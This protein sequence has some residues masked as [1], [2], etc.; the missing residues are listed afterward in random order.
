MTPLALRATQVAYDTVAADYSVLLADELAGKPLDRALLATF[1]ELV[2]GRVADVGCGPGRLSGHLRDLGLDVVGIDLSPAMVGIAQRAHP[3]LSFS[4]G[5]MTAL[6]L[7]DG[8]LGGIVAWYSV[9]HTPPALLSFVLLEFL[10]VLAPGGQLLL[11]FQAGDDEHVRKET[12]YGH[13]V[14]LDNYRFSVEGMVRRLRNTGFAVSTQV[15][16]EPVGAE[17]VRQAYVLAAKNE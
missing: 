1:S 12:A 9:I 7:P 13:A 6:D 11:A 15:L 4:V 2:S 3:Q 5:S 10:R 8:A 14:V 16:R 17:Q